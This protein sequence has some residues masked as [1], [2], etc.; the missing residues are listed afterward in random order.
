MTELR[1]ELARADAMLDMKRYDQACG[2]LARLVATEPEN[3][4][5]WCLLAR[6]H[7]GAG[8]HQQAV[9]AANRAVTLDPADEWPHRLASNALL[10]T[11]N[12]PEALRA[13]MEARRLAPGHWQ[14][15]ICVAQAALGARRLDI[16]T[17]AAQQARSLAPNEPDVHFLSGKVSLAASD[18]DSARAHQ[19]RALALDPAHSGAMN[20]LGRIRLRRHDTRGAVRHFI[21]AAR[22]SPSE[23]VYSRNIDVVILRTV[24]R[25]IYTFTLAALL[26]IWIPVIA[27]LG[28][29]PFVIGLTVLG[30]IAVGSFAWM[31]LRLPPEARLL[32]R[33]TLRGRRALAALMVAI[34][35]VALAF[36]AVA[37]VPAA[38][39]PQVLPIA[40]VATIGARL[41][42][43]AILRG[44]VPKR[45]YS[46]ANIPVRHLRAELRYIANAAP[47]V[48]E[49]DD[50]GRRSRDTR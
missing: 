42:A 16:A 36:L 24:S 11:D 32:V 39:L 17:A 30:L 35:G 6:A 23:S 10:H 49:G 31:V 4:R 3:A 20:E 45:L 46:S 48:T 15:H 26:L 22:I 8:R 21:R 34:G 25:M 28:R 14:A 40:V 37:L 1:Q 27:H 43:F 5:A 7:L 44:A 12:Y 41:G 2:V 13:G 33:R 18:L 38:E 29:F 50:R 19:E 47:G 9:D